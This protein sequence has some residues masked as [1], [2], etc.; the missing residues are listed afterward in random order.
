MN[1]KSLMR[2]LSRYAL[3]VTVGIIVLIALAFGA[4]LYYLHGKQTVNDAIAA[5]RGLGTNVA[6]SFPVGSA[7]SNVT[8]TL[9]SVFGGGT[10]Q[11]TSTNSGAAPQ[12]WRVSAA[13]TAGITFITVGTSTLARFV[14]QASGNVLDANP[15]D[16]SI[17]R[18]TNTLVP[19]VQALAWLGNVGVI[20]RYSDAKGAESFAG[21]LSGAS[22]TT[23]L[24]A[25]QA[26]E[27]ASQGPGT[28]TGVMLPLNLI[29]VTASPDGSQLFYIMGDGSGSVGVLANSDG[30]KAKRIW[31]S[32]LREWNSQWVGDHIL[33]TQKPAGGVEGSAYDLSLSGTLT[34]LIS[35]QPGLFVRE[36]PQTGALLYST[37]SANGALTLSLRAANGTVT[38]LPFAT[39]ADKCTWDP[40]SPT[41]IYCGVPRTIPT[42]V[43]LPDAWY[44]GSTH[45]SDSI[46]RYDTLTGAVARV[47]DPSIGSSRQTL[48]ILDPVLS[49]NGAYFGFTDAK[50]G[51]AWM[52]SVNTGN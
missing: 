28:L 24:G 22:G 15:H 37:V 38:P 16:S 13:P 10:A 21:M 43:T 45:F 34:P 18:R 8:N 17:T 3:P 32:P 51:S 39:L 42:D 30:S 36:N 11:S 1:G 4:W 33:L 44:R 29:S 23:T 47:Y 25:S 20:A 35:N 49:E 14:D 27:L 19:K 5:G 26:E 12:L 40:S 52:L 31:T 9:G 2:A 7:Y 6:A 46:W 41:V 50:T 48:D